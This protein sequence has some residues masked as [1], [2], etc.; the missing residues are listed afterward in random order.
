LDAFASTSTEG[1]RQMNELLDIQV[2]D[3]VCEME[4]AGWSQRITHF[5]IGEVQKISKTQFT[6]FGRRYLKSS[7][8]EVGRRWDSGRRFCASKRRLC[9]KMQRLGTP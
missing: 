2:G 3:K 8:V 1:E 7:G 9:L 4:R 5:R 6:A